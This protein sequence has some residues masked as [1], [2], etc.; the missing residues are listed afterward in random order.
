MN[1]IEFGSPSS[2]ISARCTAAARAGA[3]M[4]RSLGPKRAADLVL[5][6]RPEAVTA[7]GHVQAW[8]AS[9]VVADLVV[10]GASPAAG[11]YTAVDA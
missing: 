7:D 10:T 11:L 4:V 1:S 6:R 9:R 8:V 5:Q 3:G 2:L